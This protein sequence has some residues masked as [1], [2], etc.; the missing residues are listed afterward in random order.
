[1]KTHLRRRLSGHRHTPRLPFS[2]RLGWKLPAKA[3]EILK[4]NI[5][6]H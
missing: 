1:L 4:A 5:I 2:I 3:R 6:R